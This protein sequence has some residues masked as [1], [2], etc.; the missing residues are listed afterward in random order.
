MEHVKKTAQDN[1]KKLKFGM[2]IHFGLYSQ[3][4]EHE[5]HMYRHRMKHDKY[6][7][8]FLHSFNP[9]PNGMEQWV[10]TAKDMGARYIVCTSKHHDGF[11]LWNTAVEHDVDPQ[12]HIKNT[13]FYET[14]GQDVLHYLFEAGRKHRIR[15]GLYYSTIDWSWTQIEKKWLRPQ[16]HVN[17]KHPELHRKYIKYYHDQ[18]LELVK[19]FP[20]LLLLWFDGYQFNGGLLDYLEYAPLYEKINELNAEVLI[21]NNSGTA[22]TMKNMGNTDFLLFENM[23]HRGEQTGAPWPRP[24]D[25]PGEVCLTINNHWGWNAKDKNYKD[26]QSMKTLVARNAEKEANTL[27]NFGPKPNGYIGDEQVEIARKIGRL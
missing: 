19:R 8:Q 18:V 25:L 14:N 15:I 23:A 26:P 10:K 17:K 21:G 13:M 7:D 1:F 4:E 3:G 24:T 16:P 5:W 11:C 9:D 2:F 22:R 27:L 12:F 20:D 6:R